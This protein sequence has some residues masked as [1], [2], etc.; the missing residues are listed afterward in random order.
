ME[1]CLPIKESTID[2]FFEMDRLDL[3]KIIDHIKEVKELGQKGLIQSE[4]DFF[5]E[6]FSLLANAAYFA[7]ESNAEF[8]L[9][10]I[11]KFAQNICI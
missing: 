11:V 4:Q 8:Q 7:F 2:V 6:V 1:K 9:K 10:N 3:E 5:K